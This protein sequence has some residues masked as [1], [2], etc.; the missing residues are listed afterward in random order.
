MIGALKWMDENSVKTKRVNVAAGNDVLKFYE[1]YG[2]KVRSL[3]LE[4]V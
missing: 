4:Q 3:I 2:F 1:K